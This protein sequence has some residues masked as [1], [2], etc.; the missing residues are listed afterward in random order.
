VYFV[1]S[2]LLRA[3]TPP[4]EVAGY[5]WVRSSDN[6]P[7]D[8]LNGY[9]KGPG[10]T[11]KYVYRW[12]A[13]YSG[14]TGYTRLDVTG[15]IARLYLKGACNAP[16][17]T[18]TIAQPLFVNLK[19]FS[20]IQFVKLYDEQG[21]T[22]KPDGSVD[23][24]PACLD[25][26]FAPTPTPTAT[27][28][29]SPT[30]TSTRTITPTPTKRPTATPQYTLANVYF[31]DKK[32]YDSGVPP[33]EAAGKRWV[34]TNN[35]AANVLT[36]FF[37][38]PGATEKTTYGWIAIYSGATGFSKLDVA[39]GIARV[40]LKGQCNSQGATYTIA[41]ELRVNL[42]QFSTIIQFVKIYDQNGSTDVPD[43][44]QDSIPACLEP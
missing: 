30:P 24:I 9:F 34:L 14:F 5:R 35:L 39:D 6:F 13:I 43:G 33:F 2:V 17:R 44:N 29:S 11:E 21:A 3:G 32:R 16:D 20:T 37:K 1:N 31:V 18:Y 25:P 12:I 26:A 7:Q 22:E 23:S 4:F 40:Y 28:S 42:K 8:V 38:G 10:D 15:G 27:L 41:D 19:Q 36:E